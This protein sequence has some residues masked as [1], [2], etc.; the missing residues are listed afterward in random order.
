MATNPSLS[1]DAS[2]RRL[3]PVVTDLVTALEKATR[4]RGTRLWSGTLR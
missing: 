3:D 4:R 2:R 1:E